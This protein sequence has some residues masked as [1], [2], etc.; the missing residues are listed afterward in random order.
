MNLA[1]GQNTSE[2]I[3]ARIGLSET[4]ICCVFPLGIA[5][6][7]THTPIKIHEIMNHKL[8]TKKSKFHRSLKLSVKK[9]NDAV[10]GFSFLWRFE[11]YL[12]TYA[13]VR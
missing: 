10:N 5:H 9:K 7:H 3:V 1:H 8:T 2:L 13:V 11:I 12:K 6:T 4:I